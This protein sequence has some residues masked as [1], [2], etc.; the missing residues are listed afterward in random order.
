MKQP[1]PYC[2]AGS[3]LILGIFVALIFQGSAFATW[4]IVAVD[5]EANEV[6]S[7][8]A[9]CT[10]FVAGIVGIA[11]ARGVIVAQARSNGQAREEGVRLLLAGAS[12]ESIVAA[13]ANLEF[14]PHFQEQQYG[15]AALGFESS[16][17]GFTG[18]DTHPWQGHATANGVA[19][20]GNIL[21]GPEVIKATLDAFEANLS[22]P[23]AERLLIALE[24]G[25]A[26]G[27]DKRCGE[28]GALS[29]YL[30]V[31]R[32]G[33][34]KDSYSVKIIVPGQKPGG[35][36]PVGVLRQRFDRQAEE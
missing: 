31:S 10:G 9:S 4:S 27:G 2:P 23:L 7:A 24:A 13:V 5:A 11:P 18:T 6:G 20:Q 36:N 32:P 14:D 22:L 21:T 17:A 8:G 34:T 28:Q 12:P 26:A 25:D 16:T 1:R 30:V 33:E 35:P 3:W 19:V 15:V 29:S